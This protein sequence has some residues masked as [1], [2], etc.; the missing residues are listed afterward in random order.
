MQ[1]KVL[2]IVVFI[3]VFPTLSNAQVL[4]DTIMGDTKKDDY[5][6][7]VMK[8]N[9]N[10]YLIAG[11]KGKTQNSSA[12]F[13]NCTENGLISNYTDIAQ[14]NNSLTIEKIIN[15]NSG[16]FLLGT[17]G[18]NTENRLCLYSFNNNFD[19]LWQKEYSLYGQ[20]TI[21][22]N[23]IDYAVNS[24]NEIIVMGSAGLDPFFD[25]KPF[26]FKTNF[27]GDSLF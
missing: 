24:N 14:E 6:M 5:P 26:T 9:N 23:F 22:C 3:L 8:L 19:F 20:D 25:A 13:F 12:F 11:F 18:D 7:A 27:N 4:F 16:F 17:T 15:H 2:Y 21:I 10:K 1:N